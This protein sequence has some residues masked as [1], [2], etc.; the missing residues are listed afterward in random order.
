M[1]QNLQNYL[2]F[3][4]DSAYQ[5]GRLTL[6]YFQRDIG[7]EMKD[8]QTPVTIADREAEELIRS[9]IEN[10]YP[11]HAILGEELG[12]RGEQHAS[13]RWI[14]DPIDGTKSFIR[15]VPLYAV[16]IGLEI[17]GVIEVGVV[18]FPA[19]DEMVY[20][21]SGL[22]CFWNGRPARVR[23]TKM[24]GQAVVS[25]TDP[26]SFEKFSRGE[27]WKRIKQ[28]TYYRVGWSDA[29]GY[30][31][32]AT[33]RIEIMLDPIMAPWDAA[34]FPVILREAGGYFGDWSGKETI[35]GGEGLSTTNELLPKVLQLI[36]GD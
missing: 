7:V 23:P 20:A 8:D 17:D 4:L 35:Y 11:G 3:A 25:F 14:I 19:L 22:G 27:A 1:N 30:A 26:A 16:L 31:L 29:Y 5:A 21:A 36:E 13:H 34:P 9:R 6:G 28:R 10:T 32:V 33:G 12:T 24:L 2:S 18:N 15:G